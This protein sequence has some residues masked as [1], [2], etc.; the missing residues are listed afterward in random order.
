MPINKTVEVTY[1]PL[2]IPEN[3]ELARDRLPWFYNPDTNSCSVPLD[4]LGLVQDELTI[5]L[6]KIC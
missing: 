3:Y 4:C 6:R 2:V 1:E 5:P